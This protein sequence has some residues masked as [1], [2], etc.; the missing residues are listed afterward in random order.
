MKIIWIIRYADNTL[1]SHYGT[2]E[3]AFEIAEKNKQY[4][5]GSYVII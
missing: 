5:G 4:Y 3:E 1:A 2:R